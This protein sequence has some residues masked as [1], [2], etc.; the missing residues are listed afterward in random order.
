M[1]RR[2]RAH[3]DEAEILR[4][5]EQEQLSQYEI[6]HRLGLS[7][8]TVRN[9]LVK[10]IQPV[11][12][13]TAAMSTRGIPA[14]D[15]AE[16]QPKRPHWA[17]LLGPLRTEQGQQ[18]MRELIVWWQERTAAIARASDASR[19]TERITFHVERR[20]VEALRRKSDL[21]EMTLTQI[22]NEAFRQYFE[23]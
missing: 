8:S 5:Y 13:E 7:R 10:H 12:A 2:P 23:R 17:R 15:A 11:Q 16:P 22:V 18:A 21:D 19:Q 14:V 6:A 9:R 3:I 1:P 20:W 4:L